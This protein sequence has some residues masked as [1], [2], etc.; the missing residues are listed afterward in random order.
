[1]LA[2]GDRNGVLPIANPTVELNLITPSSSMNVT[3]TEPE[4]SLFSGF[5]F[6][7]V[8]TVQFFF[9][10]GPLD[11]FVA[12]NSLSNSRLN[13]CLLNYVECY[14][15]CCCPPLQS[16]MNVTMPKVVANGQMA[17][18]TASRNAALN[19]TVNTEAFSSPKSDLITSSPHSSQTYGQCSERDSNIVSVS[20]AGHFKSILICPEYWNSIKI[21]YRTWMQHVD[22]STRHCY[23]CN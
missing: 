9:S 12:F 18:D 10:S 7:F 5:C 2:N 22:R 20:P 8:Q 1:M 23:R 19:D 17:D 21:L 15:F 3:P 4:V 6:S 13:W 11:T 14:F 16:L